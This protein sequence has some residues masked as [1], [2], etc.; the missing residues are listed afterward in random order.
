MTQPPAPAKPTLGD[1]IVVSAGGDGQ[2]RTLEEA[3]QAHYDSGAKQPRTITMK[4][5]TYRLPADIVLHTPI[6]I[7]GQGTVVLQGSGST[8]AIRVRQPGITLRDLTITSSAQYGLL[9]VGAGAVTLQNCTITNSREAALALT[10]TGRATATNCTLTGANF[11]AIS[12]GSS[13]ASLT[14]CTFSGNGIGVQARAGSTIRLTGG[15]VSRNR[16]SGMLVTTGGTITGNN[17]TIADNGLH[18]AVARSGRIALSGGT[19]TNNAQFGL[20]CESATG[21]I[22]KSGVTLVGNKMADTQGC[23]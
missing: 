11:G 18:G 20:Y 22:E 6:E 21:V 19:V 7:V 13:Q 23:P 15:S 4:S 9:V 17:L 8:A 16:Q 5:G 14:G 2:F 12:D 10:E 3:L 1:Q